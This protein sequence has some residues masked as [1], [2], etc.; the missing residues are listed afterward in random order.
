MIKEFKGICAEH[1]QYQLQAFLLCS[2]VHIENYSHI[3]NEVNLHYKWQGMMIGII[4]S[5]SIG[6]TGD[7]FDLFSVECMLF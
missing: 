3:H 1:G 4:N 5:L 6:S 2:V 7:S